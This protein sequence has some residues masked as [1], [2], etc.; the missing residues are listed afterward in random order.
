MS[1]FVQLH[2]LTFYPP[3]NL[4]RDDTG[5]PKSAVMGG[6]ELL[7]ISSQA[8]K[9]AVRASDVFRQAMNGHLGD[10]TKRLG[11]DIKNN[12][13]DRGMEET[14]ADAVAK[15]LAAV[16]GNL[17]TKKGQELF[18][19]QLA[20]V[21]KNEGGKIDEV[22]QRACTDELFRDELIKAGGE[23]ALEGNK[24]KARKQSKKTTKLINDLR[25][26][27]LQISDSSVDIAMFGR[28]LANTPRYNREAA[29]QVAHAITTHK[30]AVED[31]Y[32]TAVDDLKRPE[33]LEDDS[34][35]GHVGEIGFGSGVFYLYVC[36]DKLSMA[37]PCRPPYTMT[38]CEHSFRL[39]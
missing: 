25:S 4:N 36:I 33:E 6:V 39:F 26:D 29:V 9:R 38:V 5:R 13:I 14:R 28:M 24:G 11:R 22:L 34:G 23:A 17:E 2:L 3:S 18:L 10:R 19:K 16:F 37:P 32:F 12:L 31:D 27:I 35:A 8:T 21:S 15:S 7:R 30:V 20:F 1:R